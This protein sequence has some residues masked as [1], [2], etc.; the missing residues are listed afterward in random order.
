MWLYPKE[1]GYALMII[2]IFMQIMAMQGL[3]SM[4]RLRLSTHV[5]NDYW[6][7]QTE[8]M[9]LNSSLS[10]I[11][12]QLLI[13]NPSCVIPTI[14]PATLAKQSYVWWLAQGCVFSKH[15]LYVV[16]ALGKDHCASIEKISNKQQV[17]AFYYRITLAEFK[18]TNHGPIIIFQSTL[19]KESDDPISCAST[20]HTVAR[21][22]Q[23]MREIRNMT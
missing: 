22:R 5:N 10:E 12:S 8:R 3:Y 14:S 16:E 20:P 6:E 18:Q 11:E 13:D 19:V 23:M 2:L 9:R 15:Q 17:E 21:G 1:Q 4:N 7:S